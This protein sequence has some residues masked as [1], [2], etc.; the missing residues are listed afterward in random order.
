MK[1]LLA[2]Y[3][4]QNTQQQAEQYLLK[5]SKI[6]PYLPLNSN[7]IN[8]RIFKR[9]GCFRAIRNPADVTNPASESLRSL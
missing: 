6:T 1:D 4:M 8:Q 3:W 7:I 9:L 5:Y 2:P